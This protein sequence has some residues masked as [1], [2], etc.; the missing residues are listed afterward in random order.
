MMTKS[1][2]PAKKAP[3]KKT[4]AKKVADKGALEVTEKATVTKEA[5]PTGDETGKAVKALEAAMQKAAKAGIKAR[6]V[7]TFTDETGET[8][9]EIVN[10]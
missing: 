1:N 6:M 5:A 10:N 7:Y 2:A 8:T 3:A 4:A 9:N